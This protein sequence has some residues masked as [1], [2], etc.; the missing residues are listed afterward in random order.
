MEPRPI[1]I[2]LLLSLTKLSEFFVFVFISDS[3]SFDP[4]KQSPGQ[5]PIHLN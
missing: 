3:P 1:I 2:A 5:D 4:D